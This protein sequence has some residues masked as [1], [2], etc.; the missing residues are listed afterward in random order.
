VLE[1]LVQ[2]YTGEAKNCGSALIKEGKAGLY[3]KDSLRLPDVSHAA[4]RVYSTVIGKYKVI[5]NCISVVFVA[6]A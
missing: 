2:E 4:V 5:F 1:R 6:G 3:E